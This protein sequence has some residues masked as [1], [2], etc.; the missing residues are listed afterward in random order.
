M[1]YLTG[2]SPAAVL[3]AVG[4]W[5]VD[6]VGT[7]H[8]L[9]AWGG[10]QLLLCMVFHRGACAAAP[11][12]VAESKFLNNK[13]VEVVAFMENIAGEEGHMVHPAMCVTALSSS[14]PGELGCHVLWLCG[15]W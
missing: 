9:K 7:W 5:T 8:K 12:Q 4:C 11:L 10:W 3:S 2:I 14:V 6:G 13:L 15:P 1:L